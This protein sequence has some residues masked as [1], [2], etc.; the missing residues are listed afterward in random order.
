MNF[1]YVA[2]NLSVPVGG[3]EISSINLIGALRKL[4]HTVVIL[5]HSNA[6][7]PIANVGHDIV[8][9]HLAW[10][11]MGR[12][13]A[14]E[15]GVPLVFMMHSYE[16]LCEYGGMPSMTAYCNK[17]CS[18]CKHQNKSFKPDLAIANS[19]F[20]ADLLRSEY[21]YKTKVIYPSIEFDKKTPVSPRNGSILMSRVSVVKGYDR[22][23][24]IAKSLRNLTFD[25]IGYQDHAVPSP[26]S[27]V[28]LHGPQTGDLF[29]NS[30]MYLSPFRTET[31]GMMMVEAQY[32]GVP[33]IASNLCAVAHDELIQ[34]G[35]AVDHPDDIN[36]WTDKI[37]R[38]LMESNADISKVRS[39]FDNRHSPMNN[40]QLL[41]D[42]CKGL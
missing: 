23:E 42:A 38:T 28:T 22:L 26:P 41:V 33:V 35:Y 2:Q 37:C 24:D 15:L 29:G 21:G 12:Q 32:A 39:F 36:E 4:G 34:Y 40:A 16:H 6:T 31:Y 18:T 9:T 8:L 20:T 5:E 17:I 11:G 7:Q 25:V 1:L 14:N 3:A 27:N 13:V 30:S 10:S 19:N